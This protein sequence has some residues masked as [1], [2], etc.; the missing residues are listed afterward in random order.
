FLPSYSP[1]LKPIEECCW[2]KVKNHVRKTPLTPKENL[3]TKIQKTTKIVPAKD[4]RGW[5]RH[6]QK[7]FGRCLDMQHI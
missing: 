4:C 6:S 7:H 2:V 5:I 3:A 1:A